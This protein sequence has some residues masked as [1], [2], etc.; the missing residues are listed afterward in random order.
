MKNFTKTFISTMLLAFLILTLPVFSMYSN[1]ST[2]VKEDKNIV[3]TA[4]SDGRFNTLVEALNKANLVNTLEGK[5]NFTV[6]APTD[7]AFKKLPDGTVENL[8]KTENKDALK[9]ILL[10]HVSKDN[11]SSADILKLDGK[12]ITLLNGKTAN[13][14]VK[15]GAVFI[16]NAKIII[17]DIPASNGIIHVIDAVLIPEK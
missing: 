7:D 11:L 5:G 10:Y 13:I 2:Q 6:F 9:D 4:K 12:K 16:N 14:S 8:L 3:E 15:N 17:T 1:A